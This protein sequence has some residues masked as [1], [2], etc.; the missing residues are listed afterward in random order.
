M[1]RSQR[2]LIVLISPRAFAVPQPL[3]RSAALPFQ[4]GSECLIRAA[5]ARRVVRRDQWRSAFAK[6]HPAPCSVLRANKQFVNT[7]WH[8]HSITFVSTNRASRRM[9]SGKSTMSDWLR[10][11]DASGLIPACSKRVGESSS[12]R[13]DLEPRRFDFGFFTRATTS[14]PT[15]I[16]DRTGIAPGANSERPVGL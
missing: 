5:S 3:E 2:S 13:W 7:L 14:G 16:F 12:V 6:L 15:A 10:E 4:S 1:A 11:W 8:V 9:D